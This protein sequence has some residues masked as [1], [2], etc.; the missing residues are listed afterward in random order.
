MISALYGGV[1]AFI[2]LSP[3]GQ[4][5]AAG[6]RPRR[7]HVS[8]PTD[9]AS[10]TNGPDEPGEGPAV[11]R[12]KGYRAVLPCRAVLMK[13]SAADRMT[14]QGPGRA[15]GRREEYRRRRENIAPDRWRVGALHLRVAGG[16]TT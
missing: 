4:V 10:L 14:G 13:M 8:W 11:E 7:Y 3:Q 9:R 6:G 2:C 5:A 15:D 16:R 1:V 12:P